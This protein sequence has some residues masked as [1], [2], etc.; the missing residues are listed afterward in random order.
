MVSLKKKKKERKKRKENFLKRKAEMKPELKFA[1]AAEDAH[2]WQTHTWQT[3]TSMQCT[4]RHGSESCLRQTLTLGKRG[5]S[6]CSPSFKHRWTE[7]T[8]SP[9]PPPLEPP[10]QGACCAYIMVRDGSQN[11]PRWPNPD[12][13]E[14]LSPLQSTRLRHQLW[15]EKPNLGRAERTNV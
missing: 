9:I 1:L 12:P 13:I 11:Q 5:N 8:L 10:R 2:T 15:G 4:R 14:L 3:H 7:E 6:V